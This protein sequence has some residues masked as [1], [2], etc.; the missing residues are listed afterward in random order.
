M[1]IT[2]KMIKTALENGDADTLYNALNENVVFYHPLYIEPIQGRM[3]T[4]IALGTIGANIRELKWR[5]QSESESTEALEFDIQFSDLTLHGVDILHF[6]KNGKVV[7]WTIVLRPLS[8]LAK[9]Y[10]LLHPKFIEA[11]LEVAIN[12]KVQN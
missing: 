8:K 3:Q 11:G 7:E 2:R 5:S 4:L 9:L 12:N 1:D 10:E 6:N